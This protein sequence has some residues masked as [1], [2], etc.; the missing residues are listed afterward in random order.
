MRSK[1]QEEPGKEGGAGLAQRLPLSGPQFPC[2]SSGH[3]IGSPEGQL[4]DQ[5][6]P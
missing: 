4:A 5:I 6:S 2:L 1:A 3:N